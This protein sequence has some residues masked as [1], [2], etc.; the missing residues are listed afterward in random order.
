ME[1]DGRIYLNGFVMDPNAN[2]FLELKMT[3]ITARLATIQALIKQRNIDLADAMTQ[4]NHFKEQG[5]SIE[6]RMGTGKKKYR[7]LIDVYKTGL[8]V[9]EGF[10]RQAMI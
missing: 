2:A 5:H 3:I 9:V 10:L 6:S 8:S 7:H 1:Q 4:I